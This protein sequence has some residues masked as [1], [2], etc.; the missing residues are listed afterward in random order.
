MEEQFTNTTDMPQGLPIDAFMDPMSL[1][2][3]AIDHIE[4]QRDRHRLYIRI[5]YRRILRV[6]IV[7]W[8]NSEP[9]L[10]GQ[11]RATGNVILRT[12]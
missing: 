7:R 2:L 12:I 11:N 6:A 5:I 4:V 3:N 1:D 8:Q 9:Y 10:K